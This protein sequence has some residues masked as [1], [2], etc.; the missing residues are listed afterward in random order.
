MQKNHLCCEIGYKAVEGWG[1]SGFTCWGV[2]G[3]ALVLLLSYMNV[4]RMFS[5]VCLV[6]PAFDDTGFL[7]SSLHQVVYPLV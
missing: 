1:E 2:K 6:L 4:S 5:Q 3:P 7:G